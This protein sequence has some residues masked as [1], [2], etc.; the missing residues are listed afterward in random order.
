MSS[1]VKIYDGK[2]KWMYFQLKMMS[3]PKDETVFGIKSAIVFKNLIVNP[4]TI[5]KILKTKIG[6]YGDETIQIFMIKM[7]LK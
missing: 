6:S 4:S 7:H 3:Y 5:K 1:Y 2:T